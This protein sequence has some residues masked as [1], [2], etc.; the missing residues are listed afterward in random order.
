MN[1]TRALPTRARV[2][3][4][5]IHYAINAT[6]HRGF[7]LVTS[8]VLPR[9]ST[10]GPSAMK[11]VR[12]GQLVRSASRRGKAASRFQFDISIDKVSGVKA[13]Q[14]YYVK[15]SRGV[16]VAATEH[17]AAGKEHVR[18]GL[19]FGHEKVSLLVTLYR[20]GEARSF[21][22]KDAKI[23][24]IHVTPKNQE[25]TIAK[26]HFNLADFAGIPSASVT[27][28][29]KL[30]DKIAIR[31]L[32]ESRFVKS[33]KSGPGSAGA[34]SALSGITGVSGRSS[35]A[36][37]FD[38]LNLEDVPDPVAPASSESRAKRMNGGASGL[39]DFKRKSN[40]VAD[41]R[42]KRI[43]STD[44][45]S[46]SKRTML[47]ID[48][49]AR[50]SKRV[51]STEFDSKLAKRGSSS[52]TSTSDSNPKRTTDNADRPRRSG[53]TR[54]ASGMRSKRSMSSLEQTELKTKR[55][56]GFSGLIKSPSR[57]LKASRESEELEKLRTDYEQLNEE[58]RRSQDK[59]RHMETAHQEE[60]TTIRE[61]LVSEMS[62]VDEESTGK[63]STRIDELSAE[64]SKLKAELDEA[65]RE[66]ES[67]RQKAAEVDKLQRKN[68]D[69]AVQ[70]DK[71][72]AAA[73]AASK[74]GDSGAAVEALEERLTKTRKEKELLENKVKAH[75]SHAEKVRDTY[76][77]LSTMY[78]SVREENIQLQQ[79]LESARATA[80]AAA[81][82]AEAAERGEVGD[83]AVT[84]A[85]VVALEAQLAPLQSQLRS[86]NTRAQDSDTAKVKSEAELGR[87]K[88]QLTA[89]ESKHE[90]TVAELRTA[91][92]AEEDMHG[93]IDELKSQ[94]DQ[95]LQRALSKRDS[96]ETSRDVNGG[97]A[98]AVTL[99]KIREESEREVGKARSRVS[100]LEEDVLALTEDVNYEK[101]EKIKAR[102]ERDALRENVRSLER[103][104]SEAMLAQD[105]ISAMRRKLSTQ[106]MR[107]EDLNAMI[108]QLRTEVKRFEE[109]ANKSRQISRSGGN[110]DVSEILG[111]LV[112]TKLELAQAEDEKLELRFQMKQLKKAERAIQ[113]RLAAHA[114]SL[115]VKL[116]Q[117]HEQIETLKVKSGPS[118][119]ISN[120]DV[121]L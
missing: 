60:L 24:L 115:E 8:R 39:L 121:S 66:Q 100:E 27:R 109:E 44:P 114:S 47:G 18:G 22:E 89:L 105:S 17:R 101:A 64:T 79:D 34:S 43:P 37:D 75:K 40:G 63:M 62:V 103:R 10:P 61:K 52:S 38:D 23:S 28:T 59:R 14:T 57:K 93:E 2:R 19:M 102:E 12:A 106:M 111:V 16:K 80:S 119:P 54:D 72:T 118:S 67:L 91:K 36:D 113:E 104:T 51:D 85:R 25:R 11:K 69:L 70:L 98:A 73:A 6:P 29:F 32:V 7:S 53:K 3:E 35:E 108:S 76:E 99:G 88:A 97:E 31:A 107:E 21:D 33:T 50:S 26:M 65:N 15:W 13:G 77:K 120:A 87:V 4:R 42:A 71:A 81:E 56:G 41:S 48:N 46:K 117:A 74:D 68:R 116:G 86:A 58:L 112:K 5:V 92:D 90:K 110:E 30:N 94:R 96:A 55:S 49:A 84:S 1:N 83:G 82:A 78:S 95:A 45:D 9:S 20:E